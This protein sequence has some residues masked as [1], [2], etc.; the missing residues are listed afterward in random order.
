MA[1]NI[2][3]LGLAIDT[4][5]VTPAA[6]NYRPQ[7]W[8]PQRDFPIV[9]DADGKVVSRYGDPLWVISLWAKKP[10]S[11]NFGDG[12]LQKNSPRITSANADLLRQIAAWWLYGPKAVQNA[13]T[14]K[15]RFNSVRALFILCSNE[16]ITASELMRFPVI[17]DKIPSVFAPS[18]ADSALTL[19]H[20]LYEQRDQ[21]GFTLLD[22]EGLT[23]LEA[24]LPEHETRQTPY[25]PPRI[26]TYQV[27]RL[28][29]FLD[30][31]HAHRER[32]EACYRFC[33]DAYAKNYGSL[34]NAFV[35]KMTSSRNPFC[36]QTTSTGAITGA[37]FHGPFSQTAQHFGIGELLQKW[38]HGP[39]GPQA[40]LIIRDLVLY[41]SMV[42]YVGIA[43][44]LNFSLMRIQES[45]SLRTDCLE[46]ENDERFGPIY[47]L[48]GE[49]T[50]TTDDDNARWPTSPSV[51]VAVDAM[52]CVTRLRMIS[53]EA[54]P[55]VP[56][57]AEDISNPHLV[58][59][60]YEPWAG[61][62]DVDQTSSIR[63]RPLRYGTWINKSSNLFDPEE[64]RIT[65]A[66]LQIARLA[67]PTLDSETF[68]VGKIWPLA[69]H[70]LRRTGAVNMQA[71]GL[72]SDASLQYQL[73]HATRAMSLYY[74]HGYSR[75]R[76][77]EEARN[78][79]IRTMYEVLGKEVTRLFS[80]RFVSPHGEK[81]KTEILKLVDPNDSKKLTDLAKSGKVSYRETLLG[82]CTN[83]VPCSFGG[84]DN[85]AACGGGYEKAP[86]ASIL[87]DREKAPAIRQLGRV[88]ASRLVE[89]QEGSPY[90]ESLEAQQRTVEKV[91]H[92]IKSQ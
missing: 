4:P 80:D 81:R 89:A 86:C 42:S 85:V 76:L 69:W 5:L 45:W 62:I 31:F 84:I 60:A 10:L 78:T 82:C 66:D 37:K 32:I 70:Q 63:V 30:D 53:A 56:A 77:N 6:L 49:T 2:A 55:N 67:N 72:V 7:T 43:Y 20:A 83:P 16:G 64:L 74:G 28:R 8:P 50:K 22:R 59:R 92:V 71:S 46:I 65:E 73:K 48:H 44:L 24:A 41:M 18:S 25:I 1:I 33:L 11:L 47:I 36:T 13:L 90:R 87:Y 3:Y 75:V 91:L 23:R 12:P 39:G 54:N 68:A 52:T 57:T 21:L 61:G 17:A 19:L 26:W 40:D 88:I 14:L 27:N 51:K 34:G 15:T 58:V 29:A 35:G 9:I 38:C 79:Y